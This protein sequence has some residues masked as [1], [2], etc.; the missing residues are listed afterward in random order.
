M[1]LK[2]YLNDIKNIKNRQALTKIRISAHSLQIEKRK[3][4]RPE[5]Y[6]ENKEFVNF[7]QKTHVMMIFTV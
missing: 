5:I 1:F 4:C 3:Y 2:E 6:Q 7:V